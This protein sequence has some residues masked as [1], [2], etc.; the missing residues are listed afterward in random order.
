MVTGLIPSMK[1]PEVKVWNF[2]ELRTVCDTAHDLNTKVVAH[3]RNAE[4]TRDA[5]RAGVDLIYHASY[6]DDEA[7]EAVVDAGAALCPTF[8]LLGNVLAWKPTAAFTCPRRPFTG[9]PTT[10]SGPAPCLASTA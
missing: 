9:T 5:A 8:T 1:G 7:L 4:S 10:R 3:C 2:D 6:M